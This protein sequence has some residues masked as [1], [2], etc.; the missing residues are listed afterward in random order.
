M[1][2]VFALYEAQ[3]ERCALSGLR[4]DLR[5]I[6]SGKARRPFAPSLD[7]IDSTGGY[8]RDNVRLVC[9]GVNFAL[10][11]YGEDTFR[12]IAAATAAFEPAEVAP[13]DQS[14]RQRKS[15]YIDH[16]VCE[17]PR[18]LAGH[19]GELPKPR[20]R[21]LLRQSFEGTLPVD[22]ANAYGWGFRRLTEAGVIEPASGSRAYRL[23]N[24]RSGQAPASPL[25]AQAPSAT[26]I[27]PHSA[28]LARIL[29]ERDDL[30]PDER[31]EIQRALKNARAH[32]S[33]KANPPA[34]TKAPKA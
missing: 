14:E 30:T 11:A 29:A 21:E 5:I 16:V 26:E 3:G 27:I 31:A 8:T 15:A 9:Q 22:E 13:A 18:I 33:R 24:A 17:A 34:P 28:R 12:E 23:R 1:S 25:K 20:M 10:N 6:G 19:G 32:E 4:F 2:L 7:R